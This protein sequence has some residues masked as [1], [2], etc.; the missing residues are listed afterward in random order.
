[1]VGSE[2]SDSVDPLTAVAAIMRSSWPVSSFLDILDHNF[3]SWS[4]NFS[5]LIAGSIVTQSSPIGDSLNHYSYLW[6]K[7][8]IKLIY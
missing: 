7:F 5:N 8:N 3:R 2:L 6:I 4:S 1:M